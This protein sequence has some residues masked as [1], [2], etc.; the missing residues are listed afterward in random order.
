MGID[1]LISNIENAFENC[2]SIIESHPMVVLSEA[3]FERLLCRCISI[4][5]NE[6][7]E[8]KP[9]PQEFS[10]HTQISHYFQE[11][12]K[13]KLKDRVDILIIDETQMEE[14]KVHKGGQYNGTSVALELKY[15]RFVDSVTIAKGDFEKWDRLK[16]DSNLYVVALIDSKDDGDFEKKKQRLER[17]MDKMCPNKQFGLHTLSCRC[18]KKIGGSRKSFKE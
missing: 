15:I 11:N 2:Q 4:Q 14:C 13:T 3:D 7:I 8:R 10:V 9:K 18:L 5:L 16:E 12:G 1:E 17:L 6:S